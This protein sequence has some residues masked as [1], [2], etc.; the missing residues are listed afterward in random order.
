[1]EQKSVNLKNLTEQEWDPNIVPLVSV[2]S[3]V[4]N[5]KDFIRESIESILMQQTT[6]PVEVIIHDDA[7][8][9]GT[10][11]IILEYEKK[12]P[13]V[14]FKNILQ[15]ENQWSQGKSVMT[16][17]G[18]KPI[19]K[20]IALTHGDDYWTDP[21][22]LQKQVDFLNK[23]DEYSF[24][25]SSFL[26]KNIITGKEEI[27]YSNTSDGSSKFDFGIDIDIER[28]W[29]KWCLQTLTIMYRNSCF[30]YNNFSIKK[31]SN[32]IDTHLF[33]ELILKGKGF[34]FYQI[35]GVQNVIEKSV[36]SNKSNFEK[37]IILFNARQ[38][39]YIAHPNDK[40][41]Q[42]KLFAVS[43]DLYSSYKNN[44]KISKKTLFYT[45]VRTC[46]NIQDLKHFFKILINKS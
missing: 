16:P 4:Y 8:T 26:C 1:M 43:T 46:R 2:F 7:S 33:Y 31:Y 6:F 11:E 23:N 3:W 15:T 38:E 40:Y 34:Y 37:N 14:I 28:F 42:R 30:N 18:E 32:P 22:K 27:F 24:V 35:F 9:D 10:K 39:I 44:E 29:N 17:M 13:N 36:Y 5:H 25:T 41:L 21:L 12:Y 19:G 20:Y 45:M